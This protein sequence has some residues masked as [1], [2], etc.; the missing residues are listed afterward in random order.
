MQLRGFLQYSPWQYR[1]CGL[2]PAHN[3]AQELFYSA[4]LI[5]AF[6]YKKYSH[7]APSL[8]M[9]LLCKTKKEEMKHFLKHPWKPGDRLFSP[10]TGALL[11][12][13]AL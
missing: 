1:Q 8:A 9:D 2:A 5:A 4:S 13:M 12:I 10:Q 3:S 6:V 7:I 11:G